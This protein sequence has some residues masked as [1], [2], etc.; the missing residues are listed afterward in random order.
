MPEP[1]STEPL[2]IPGLPDPI[3]PEEIGR[4]IPVDAA[5]ATTHTTSVQAI[6][7]LTIGPG[8]VEWKPFV[9]GETPEQYLMPLFPPNLV[10]LAEAALSPDRES[11]EGERPH[12]GH[13]WWVNP[14]FSLFYA[15]VMVWVV[16]R[17]LHRARLRRPGRLQN[18]VEMALGGLRRIFTEILG[19]NADRHVPFLGSLWLFI[20]ANNLGVLVPGLKSPT[21]SFKTTIALALATFFY[22]HC[23]AI[24]ANG[25]LGWLRH[26]IGEPL[27]M[28]PMMLPLHLIGEIVRP[29]S[30]ALRLFGSMLGDDKLLAA[31][32]G[33]GML[34]AASIFDT[35]TPMLGVP[36]H[37]AFYPLVVLLG[38]IQAT[39]FALLAA[40]YLAVA[41]PGEETE[42]G[43]T[44]ST[45]T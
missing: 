2:E 28:A 41:L 15:V 40:T 20:L 37:L 16:R 38:A 30:L 22:I 4:L 19:R 27:W 1:P 9:A 18:A 31:F 5:S 45:T 21:Y 7:V 35:P 17:A 10:T 11:H 44:A 13:A 24:R 8:G 12:L 36:L 43:S 42:Q 34:M 23:H 39:V 33:M 3:G 32:L 25:W 26:L 29:C 6:P 14:L